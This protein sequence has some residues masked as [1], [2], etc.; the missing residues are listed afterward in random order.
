[1][2]EM[3]MLRPHMV[4]SIGAVYH[5]PDAREGYMVF[6]RFIAFRHTAILGGRLP[7]VEREYRNT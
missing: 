2:S 5:P 6:N 7:V 3:A 1:M 4:R